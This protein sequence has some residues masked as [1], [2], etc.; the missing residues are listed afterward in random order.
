M[1]NQ[2]DKEDMRKIVDIELAKVVKRLNA[3]H[4]DLEVSEDVLEFLVDK[5]FNIDFADNVTLGTPRS[6]YGAASGLAGFWNDCIGDMPLADLRA[7]C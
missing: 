5:S 1:F 2:L 6:T 7:W 3:K 4:H